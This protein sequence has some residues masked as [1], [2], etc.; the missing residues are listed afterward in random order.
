[1]RSQSSYEEEYLIDV[2]LSA[3]NRYNCGWTFPALFKT[4]QSLWVLIS[5]TGTDSRYCGCRLGEFAGNTAKI[6]FPMPGEN[7]GSGTIE[8]AFALPG[9]TPW[10]TI[11]VADNL[12]PIVETTIA[13]DVVKPKYDAKPYRYGRSSWSW[14]IWDDASMNWRDQVAF[15][16]FAAEMGWEYILV[17]ALWDTAKDIGYEKLPELVKYAASKGVGVFLW[18]NSNG[19]WNDTP[20]GP[21]EVM[22][23]PISRKREMR[24]LKSLGVKGLKVDFWGGDKQETFRLYEQV[25]SDADDNDLMIIFHGC[26]IPRGWE[27]MYPNYVGS[28]A[29]LASENRHFS[30]HHCDIAGLSASLHPFIRNTIGCMEYGGTFLNERMSRDNKK[31]H[32]RGTTVDFELAT[33]IL[34]QNPIQNFALTPN[35]LS[36]APGYAIDFMRKVPTTWDETRYVAGYPG[37]FA[38]IARRKADKWYIG[39]VSAEPMS[40]EVDFSPFGGAVEKIEDITEFI[41][42]TA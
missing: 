4:E 19:A 11:T 18:Y 22:S 21:R 3:T 16:D 38:V 1:M 27:R 6:E 41:R 10:R 23:D 34:F 40:I 8:P 36:D 14:I 9:V 5:E 30:K 33:A 37:K 29:V 2:P 17:D 13:W 42:C 20:Q 7:N 32:P 24:W 26:T 35:N 39:G 28:E 25:L 31:K 12:A 15:I